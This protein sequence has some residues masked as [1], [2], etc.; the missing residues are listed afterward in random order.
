MPPRNERHNNENRKRG[1]RIKKGLDELSN[2]DAPILRTSNT[3]DRSTD[4]GK[5]PRS[6]TE[7]AENRTADSAASATEQRTVF[8]ADWSDWVAVKEALFPGTRGTSARERDSSE[9]GPDDGRALGAALQTMQL[10]TARQRRMASAK[11]S[12]VEVPAYV[13]ATKLIVEAQV[14]DRMLVVQP[15]V[16][17]WTEAAGLAKLSQTTSWGRDV[18]CGVYGNAVSR[19]VHLMTGSLIASRSFVNEATTY[20]QRAQAVGFPE[21]AVEL[22]QRIAH[23]SEPL[24]TELRW[25]A[26]LVLQ[27]LH[28][29][30]WVVQAS[31]VG[32]IV[33]QQR[34]VA[35][36]TERRQKKRKDEPSKVF[37]VGDMEALLSAADAKVVEAASVPA[38]PRASLIGGC[39]FV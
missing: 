11:T 1:T 32:E 27:H 12:V 31:H 29:A 36:Q 16:G 23:G 2:L 25:V 19:A 7:L 17:N 13:E 39:S 34:R 18:V 8:A 22:R 9:A 20:R 33:A 15:R 35:E 24:L 37:S 14:A 38:T 28:D 4:G 30:Y 5:R 26:Q 21:E 6:G 3:D 10:W